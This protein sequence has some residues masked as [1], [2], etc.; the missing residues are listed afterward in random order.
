[1]SKKKEFKQHDFKMTPEKHFELDK[2]IDQV[3]AEGRNI[4]PQSRRFIHALLAG[5]VKFVAKEDK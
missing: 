1:M 4:S 3:I 2:I 5:K